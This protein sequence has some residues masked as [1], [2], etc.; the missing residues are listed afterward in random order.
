M[1]GELQVITIC[2][3]VKSE[4]PEVVKYIEQGRFDL[5]RS[6]SHKFPLKEIN[7]AYAVLS[8]KIKRSQYDQMGHEGFRSK[9][10]FPIFLVDLSL[11]RIFSGAFLLGVAEGEGANF[12]SP[13]V[14]CRVVF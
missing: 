11:M 9:F 14:T 6:V 10:D 2:D 4:I 5:S 7:E 3:H 1:I 13:L 8:D 12:R